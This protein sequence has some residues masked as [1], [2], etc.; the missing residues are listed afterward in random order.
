[1]REYL[2]A[3]T[4][5]AAAPVIEKYSGILAAA[6]LFTAGTTFQVVQSMRL[7][8]GYASQDSPRVS[9]GD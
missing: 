8:L 2:N 9:L 3:T 1:M 6:D 7:D 5:A 4:A